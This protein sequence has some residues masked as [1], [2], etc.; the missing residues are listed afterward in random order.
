MIVLHSGSFPFVKFYH[1]FRLTLRYCILCITPCAIY[2]T[3]RGVSDPKPLTVAWVT[4]EKGL[5]GHPTQSSPCYFG[6]CFRIPNKNTKTEGFC[7]SVDLF[8]SLG[9]RKP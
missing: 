8:V 4:F 2:R 7:A 9:L 3:L 6:H 1:S 5:M